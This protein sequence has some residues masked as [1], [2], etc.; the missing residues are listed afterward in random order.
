MIEP[1]Y[2]NRHF[3]LTSEVLAA[4]LGWPD[5]KLI[6]IE[7]SM[8]RSGVWDLVL[9]QPNRTRTI[10]SNM[11]KHG[12]RLFVWGAENIEP[13][14]LEQARQATTLPFVPG[15][16]ALMPD[17]HV[18]KGCTV[19]SVVPTE[20]AIVPS[21]VGVD[22]GCGMIAIETIYTA[23]HL[24]DNL[25]PIIPLLSERIPAG[26]GKGHVDGENRNGVAYLFLGDPHTHLTDKQ[27]ATADTQLGTLGSGNHFAEVCVDERGI[28]WLVLHSGSR[29]IGNQLATQHIEAAKGVMKQYFI[30]LDDP[31]LA[32]F[33]EGT[34]EFDAYIRDMLWAQDYAAKSREIM[35]DAFLKTLVEIIG[36]DM[37][38]NPEVSRI[39]CHH[40]YSSR[41][42]HLGRELWVTRKGAIKADKG[43]LGVIPGSM[44][45]HS[46]IVRGKGNR[47]SFNSS[48]HGAGRRLSRGVARRTLDLDGLNA[49]MSGKSWNRDAK[50]LLDE[51]PRA[52]KSIEDVMTAQSDLTEIV[53]ELTQLVN[54]KGV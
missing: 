49:A 54:Y 30:H 50:A 53:H 4:L 8:T 20:G 13:N 7:K 38:T 3:S 25:D 21:F 14:T 41:E 5:C 37:S 34:R 39:N 27:F 9:T 44:G 36:Y 35:A 23:D 47:A 18:G 46:Y 31:A 22:I 43:D 26:V 51:D 11:E 24:P 28:V 1:D 2:I 32:Y 48:S 19:G 16:V 10:R 45:T 15:H 33:V 17:A 6:K 52:Y 12:E 29:G 40:N 42:R